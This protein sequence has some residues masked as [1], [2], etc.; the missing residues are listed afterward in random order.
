[1]ELL[2]TV[3]GPIATNVANRASSTNGMSSIQS[4]S[5][6]FIIVLLIVV[7]RSL[8]A[9]LVTL[10]P[11]AL[12][13]VMSMRFSGGLGTA[14]LKIS[15]VTQVLLIVL[16]LGAGTDYGLFLV[17]RMREQ[18]RHGAAP[19]DAL[20]TA[21]TRVGQAITYS[22]LTVAAALMTL[23]LAPFGIY[24]GLGPALAIGVG[25]MLAASLTLT[26]ALL[27]I[28]GRAVFWPAMPKPGPQHSH[29]A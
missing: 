11:S 18:I 3:V 20:V 2:H 13:L 15:S 27:A 25:V 16:L 28:F 1:M 26:P 12:A 4:F 19:R 21:V 17:F 14:G 22:G 9:A 6:L 24:R 10:I 8:L 29:P 5:L 7:F 23:L